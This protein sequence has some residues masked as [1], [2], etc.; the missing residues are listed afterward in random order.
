MLD[1]VPAL[2]PL[3][4]GALLQYSDL[5]AVDVDDPASF[6]RLGILPEDFV[7]A[8]TLT[9]LDDRVLV[10]L[11][12]LPWSAFAG[13]IAFGV[14]PSH[15][16]V[17]GVQAGNLSADRMEPAMTDSGFALADR[18]GVPVF[19]RLDD[20][21]IDFTSRDAAHPF[22]GGL[23]TAARVAVLNDRLA[24]ARNWRDLDLMLGTAAGTFP[25]MAARPDVAALVEAFAD[26]GSVVQAV[27]TATM[28]SRSDR[29]A[30]SQLE[31]MMTNPDG[32]NEQP[33]A[34]DRLMPVPPY[35]MMGLADLNVT[36][37]TAG[38]LGLVYRDEDAARRAADALD[39]T[40]TVATRLTDGQPVAEQL[41]E[42]WQIKVLPS[43]DLVTV[44][45]LFPDPADGEQPVNT[46]NYLVRLYM[47]RDLPLAVT[48]VP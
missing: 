5:T 4:D 31:A 47:M 26:Q 10:D 12:G 32:A 39:H 23:S 34:P 37:G 33:S 19:W 11:I 48:S 6:R 41:T 22:I 18:D 13:T 28:E 46:F 44:V 14:P 15:M 45:M 20:N 1:T 27:M 8:A 30:L 17:Y 35:A 16:A 7:M 38:A 29:D 9:G 21:Q 43:G 42:G 25:S 24:R 36:S 40:F 3:T 2:A